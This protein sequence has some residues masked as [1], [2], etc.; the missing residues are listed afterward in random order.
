MFKPLFDIRARFYDMQ[1]EPATADVMSYADGNERHAI[2]NKLPRSQA[3]WWAKRRA[4]D[5]LLEA[6]GGVVTR[7]GDETVGE[8]WSLYDGQD[9]LDEAD[10]QFSQNI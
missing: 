7:V 5:T 9:V 8:M 1:H 4:T 10:P 3:D 2:A 6:V